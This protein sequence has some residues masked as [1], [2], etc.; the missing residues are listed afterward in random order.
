MNLKKSLAVC[1]CAFLGACEPTVREPAGVNKIM[2]HNDIQRTGW[3][4]HET[5]LTHTSVSGPDFGLLWQSPQFDPI[6]GNEARLFASPLYVDKVTIFVGEHK[7]KTLPVV[8]A[9]PST[10]YIYAVSADRTGKAEAGS[11]LWRTRLALKPCRKGRISILSTPVIDLETRRLYAVSCDLEKI[12]QLHALDIQSGKPVEGWP[13]S[14]SAP[15]VN[16]PGMNKNGTT[17]FPNKV[18]LLQRGALTF[19]PQTSRLY[20]P[21]GKDTVSGWIIAVDTKKAELVTAFST[22]AKTEEHQGGMWASGGPS[23]DPEGRVHIATGAS[24][25]FAAKKAGIAGVF[26]DS[27]HNWGQSIIQLT[28][29]V[30]TG[31]ELTGTY[32]PFDYC[33]AQS[34]DIDLGSSGTIV[35]DLDPAT[36][37]TPKL[38]ALIGGKQGM[39]YLLDRDNMPGSLIKR[40]GCSDDSSTDKS[41]LAPG[42]QPPFGQPGPINLFKPYSVT[43]GWFDYAKSRT[44]GAYFQD[45][46]GV[47]YLFGTGGTKQAV[48]SS[49]N[50]PPSLGR[51]KIVTQPGEPAYMVIDQM[52]QTTIFENPSSPVI[53]SNGAEE[54]IVWIFDQNATRR[55]SPWADNPPRPVLYAYSALTFELLWKSAPG[56]LYASG[57][58]NEATVVNGMV[59]VGTD[60]IQAF[61]LKQTTEERK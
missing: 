10:G 49:V 35:I 15:A 11:I 23:I 55:V 16:Q 20:I 59:Y 31:F 27:E 12:Y 21:F 57:K 8:F 26:P 53:S 44:T 18:I 32:T 2:Y 14:I 33:L 9:A 40:H 43:L 36:T 60:R 6:E 45:S 30:E 47:G 7:G 61:G 39:A 42:D 4:K 41:L 52:E 58:Y 54:P 5:A 1:L 34:T 25:V 29:N 3:N 28:D 22:T 38:L 46:D 24:V 48:D 17:Q 51:L 56:I 19:N 50:I 37:S 13:I